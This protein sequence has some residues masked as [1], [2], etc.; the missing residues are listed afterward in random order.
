MWDAKTD[1]SGGLV[2]VIDPDTISVFY[3]GDAVIVMSAA[4]TSSKMFGVT[5]LYFKSRDRRMV[6]QKKGKEVA[7]KSNVEV[8]NFGYTP[9]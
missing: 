1:D 8:T 7:V 5:I 4:T 2:S 3:L 9:H 6:A